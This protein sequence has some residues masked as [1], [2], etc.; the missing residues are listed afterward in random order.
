[1]TRSANSHDTRAIRDA[2]PARDA[3]ACAAIYA[4]FVLDSP[5]SF[6]EQAPD[7]AA[8]AGRIEKV[9]ATYPWLVAERD[10]DV[11]GFAYGAPHRER[12]AYRWA[13]D[14]SVYIDGAARRQGVG[15]ALY[16]ALFARLRAQRLRVACAGITLPN[17][18][19]VA[20]HESL[21]FE[22]VGVYRDIGWKAGGW[23]DV[24]WWRLALLPPVA[25]PPEPLPP[26]RG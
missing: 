24:G 4:P 18:A 15:R 21:G 3:Q 12:A 13:A 19:S 1:M 9:A 5:V 6:E 17:A 11:V 2:D 23:R 10:G 7:A 26:Q 25:D 16:E 8:F 14:V 20:L 22:P